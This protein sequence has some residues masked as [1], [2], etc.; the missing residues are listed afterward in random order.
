MSLVLLIGLLEIASADS[1]LYDITSVYIEDIEISADT[2]TQVELEDTV[3][4]KV[5]IEGTGDSTTCPD[6]DDCEVEVKVKAWIGGYEYDDVEAISSTFDIEPGVSYRK[7]LDLEIPSDLDLDDNDYTLYV[8][9]YDNED[10]ERESFDLYIEK[11]RHSLEIMDVIYDSTVNAGDELSVEVRVKNVG[12]QKEEDIK[13]E[14]SL[15]D[16]DSASDYIDELASE[17]ED[18]E[19]EESSDSANFILDI[20]EDTESGTYN[21]NIL[22]AY[23]NDHE[24]LEKTYVITVDG[25]ETTTEESASEETSISTSSTSLE[26]K[27]G[28]DKTLELSITN[29]GSEEET[30]EIA[31]AGI[32]QWASSTVS[33]STLDLAAGET[34]KV[35][36]TLTPDADAA[37][38]HEFSIQILDS[39][40]NL[41]KEI[42][43][44]MDVEENDKSSWLKIGFMILIVL[45]VLVALIVIFKKLIQDDDDDDEDPLE[46]KEGKTYY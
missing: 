21:L 38:E 11:Q 18:N 28:D 2:A 34:E 3:E 9:V 19:D 35:S 30:Y 42:Q 44:E 37:G 15:E 41:V 40:G 39:E 5:Y 23:D 32:A 31:V 7:T 16:L 36:L 43:M 12:E 22:V 26:G 27:E 20:P 4:I 13:V 17:E 46:P 10:Y 24:T 29:P 14:V 25:T 6:V 8:E 1:D 45:I 33:P